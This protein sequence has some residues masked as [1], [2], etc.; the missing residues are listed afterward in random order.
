[1][2]NLSGE[3]LNT[4]KTGIMIISCSGHFVFY[5]LFSVSEKLNDKNVNDKHFSVLPIHVDITESSS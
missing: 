1:M 3:Y 5:N 2:K 4:F